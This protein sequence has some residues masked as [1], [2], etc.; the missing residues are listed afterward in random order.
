[1]IRI[2]LGA[3]L[4]FEVFGC[5]F[6]KEPETLPVLGNKDIVNGDTIYHEVRDFS[7][8]NQDSQVV[9]NATFEGKAYVVDFFFVSCPT[10][11]P[12]VTKQMLRVY[13]RFK[14]EDKLLLLAHTIDVKH[15]SVPRLK[16]YADNLGVKTEKWMFVTGVKDSIYGIANDY[17][18]IAVENTDA[19]GGF[20]HSGRLILVDKNRRVRSFCDGTD[21]ESVDRFMADIETLLKEMK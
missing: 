14:E 13:D 5:S 1:M 16:E 8:I 11:C 7:F 19:P 20:D 10:I 17:F 3:A 21:P 15:D 6:K 12:I 2:L 4:L 18:S 9:T